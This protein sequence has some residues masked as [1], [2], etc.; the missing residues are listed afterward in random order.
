MSNIGERKRILSE[1]KLCFNCTAQQHRANQCNSK[2]TCTICKRKHHTSICDKQ[3]ESKTLLLAASDKMVVYPVVVVKVE[4]ISCRALLDTGSGSS[5]VSAELLKHVRKKPIRKDT[6]TVDMMLNSTTR[7]IET[8]ELKIENLGGSF[9]LEIEASKDEKDKLL[10]L[11]NP[12][13]VEL[14]GK[15]RHHKGVMMNDMDVKNELPVHLILGA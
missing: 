2:R 5:Y 13:Y 3:D 10:S 6:K 14:I 4:G 7:K 1:K 9:E 11:L 15:Y 12:R 8:Y